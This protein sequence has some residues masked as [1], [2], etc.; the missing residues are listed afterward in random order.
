MLSKKTTDVLVKQIQNADIYSVIADTTP[1]LSHKDRL[2]V[3]IRYLEEQNGKL[4]PVERLL[5][6]DAVLTKK[7]GVELAEK[8]FS[9]LNSL[10]LPVEK[11]VFQCYD[12]SSNMSDKYN[13]THKKLSEICDRTIPY[14][15]CQ[16]HR[17]NIF[18]KSACNS[19]LLTKEFFSVLENVYTFFAGSTKRHKYFIEEFQKVENSLQLKNLSKTR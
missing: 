18:I 10:Q 19:S 5:K 12:F 4:V 13:G 15:P 8:I 1:D 17:L 7:T 16:A 9:I 11:I 6:I 14:I 2:A 3:N